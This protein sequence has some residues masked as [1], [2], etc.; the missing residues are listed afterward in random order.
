[1]LGVVRRNPQFKKLWLAQVVSQ[2]GDW[3]SRIAIL[4]LIGELAGA[5]AAAGMGLLFGVE[6]VIR[7]LPVALLSPIAGPVADW[8]P[9]KL[10][11][12]TADLLRAGV[13]LCYLL[14]DEPDE[15]PW[16]YVLMVAQMS[17][18]IFFDSARSASVPNTLPKEELH[19]AYALSAATWS[20][21]LALGAAFGGI[22][23]TTLGV[24]GVFVADALT[25]VVSALFL[26]R[27]ALPPVPEHPAPFRLTDVLL[28]RDL[29][30]AYAHARSLHMLPVLFAKTFWGGAGGFLVLLSIAGSSRFAEA[31][32]VLG[33]GSALF[34]GEGAGAAGFAISMLF[35]SR[36]LGTGLGPILARR[37]LGSSDRSL[38]AQIAGGFFVGAVGYALFALT[39]SLPLAM[40]CVVFAHLGGSALWVASTTFWQRKVEDAFRGRVF[41]LDFLG[42]TLSVSLG[43]LLA[44][45]LYDWSGSLNATIW[46]ICVWVLL[47]GLVW[48][49]WARSMPIEP[50]AGALPARE[51]E[52][53]DIPT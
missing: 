38:R 33:E 27:V 36:G 1:M 43:G 4:T 53:R 41:A 37:F 51:D 35:L 47:P 49:V 29:R 32:G 14:V 15:L 11:M 21:M 45:W 25:Y 17:L 7:M 44:G 31:G 3:M 26:V 20:T 9:R 5:G 48:R 39:G 24:R 34:R 42:M 13:V 6:I 50:E 23:V 19:E 16:L 10:L 18:A 28:L 22:L 52:D 12:V 30:R 46:T 8:L 2:A 40:L